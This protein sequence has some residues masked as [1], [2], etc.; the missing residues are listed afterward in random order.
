VK[1]V[2]LL[3]LLAQLLLL[4]RNRLGLRLLSLLKSLEVCELD[5][6]E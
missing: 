5:R 3:F 2:F 4:L 1:E 6:L